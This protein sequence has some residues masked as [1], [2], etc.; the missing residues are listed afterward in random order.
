MN[1]DWSFQLSPAYNM[2]SMQIK[3]KPLAQDGETFATMLYAARSYH[4]HIHF[5]KKQEDGKH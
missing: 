4:D 3:P 2:D 5:Q 1:L